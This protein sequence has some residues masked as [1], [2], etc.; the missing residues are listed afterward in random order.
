MLKYVNKCKEN[1]YL[2]DMFKTSLVYDNCIILVFVVLCA[3]T[4]RVQII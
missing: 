2:T 3:L 4:C 1:K